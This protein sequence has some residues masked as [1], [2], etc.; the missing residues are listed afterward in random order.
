MY[1]DHRAQII[2]PVG[3]ADTTVSED[4]FKKIS[5]PGSIP[6]YNLP[7]DELAAIL[8]QCSLYVGND[9]GITHLA[10]AVGTPVVALFGP[11]D[12]GVWGPRGK[13][14]SILYGKTDCSPCSREKMHECIEQICLEQLSLEEVYGKVKD[15]MQDTGCTVQDKNLHLNPGNDRP[16]KE[17]VE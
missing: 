3:P 8:K 10:A 11:T 6:L 9:S 16:N 12:P 14:V 7:L 1:S 4:Y 13:C 15:L 17:M 2:I 5:S